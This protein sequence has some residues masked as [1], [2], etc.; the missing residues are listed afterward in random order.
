[1]CIYQSSILS[2]VLP[3]FRNSSTEVKQMKGEVEDLRKDR[4]VDI[5]SGEE[6]VGDKTCAKVCAGSTGRT[7]TNWVDF[8]T[9]G[10][11]TDVDISRCGFVKIP[12]ITTA[13]EG[14]HPGYHWKATGPAAVY[15]ASTTTFWVYIRNTLWDPQNGRA[16]ATGWH[17][18][19]S[20]VGFGG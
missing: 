19:W 16:A 13:L 8:S 2:C 5:V 18:E 6:G 11:Y 15:A 9:H 1:M 12:T 4:E 10:V 3:S 7:S 14:L 17:I 20:A